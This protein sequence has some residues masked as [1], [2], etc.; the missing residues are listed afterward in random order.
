MSDWFTFAALEGVFMILKSFSAAHIP[1]GHLFMQ[2][3]F[4]VSWVSVVS[5]YKY[6]QCCAVS[7]NTCFKFFNLCSSF[8]H[9][10]VKYE[11][12]KIVFAG[13]QLL[14]IAFTSI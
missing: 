8:G 11:G 6:V 2:D 13:I 10:D 14:C 3:V 9:A 5:L 1:S 7:Y 12:I 4:I